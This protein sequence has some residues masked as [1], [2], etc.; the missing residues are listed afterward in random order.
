[1]PNQVHDTLS[2]PFPTGAQALLTS[3]ALASAFAATAAATAAASGAACGQ[4]QQMRADGLARTSHCQGCR[5]VLPTLPAAWTATH[6]QTNTKPKSKG[7]TSAARDAS[8]TC[9]GAP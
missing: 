1:M 3:A 7:P 6:R 4:H 9:D 2:K 5:M 8:D